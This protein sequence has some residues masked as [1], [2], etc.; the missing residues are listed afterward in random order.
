M[1]FLS[2]SEK[3]TFNFAQKFSSQLAGGQILG[4]IGNLGAGKT[5][6]TKGLAA[7]LGIK[8]NVSSP[9]FILMRLYS[10]N[11]PKI[12]HLIHIDAYRLTSHQDLTAIGATE[13]FNKPDALVVIEWAN[14]IKKILP[15]RTKFVKITIDKNQRTI[16]Y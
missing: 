8:K 16:N 9:T 10:V 12:K 13:Y 3:Q 2:S 4:L 5:I 11:L 15:P 1:K 6:F 14:K 7:G